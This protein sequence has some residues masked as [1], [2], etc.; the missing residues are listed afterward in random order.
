LRRSIEARI[1][2]LET[3]FI[4]NLDDERA[5]LFEKQVRVRGA[6][7]ARQWAVL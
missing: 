7:K 5:V 2:E 3:F 6:R 4:E 1:D